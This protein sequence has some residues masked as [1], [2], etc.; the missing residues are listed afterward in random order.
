MKKHVVMIFGL[1]LAVSIFAQD[2]KSIKMEDYRLDPKI[3]T[4]LMDSLK[5]EGRSIYQQNNEFYVLGWSKDGKMA[6][7]EN[8]GIEGRGG[9]DLLFVILDLVED[10]EVFNKKISWYDDDGYGEIPGN[11]MS[12]TDCI[13]RNSAEFNREL[14]KNGIILKPSKVLSVPFV[15]DKNNFFDFDINEIKHDYGEYG[16]LEMTYEIIARK[17]KS[18]KVLNRVEDKICSYVLPTGYLKSPYENRIAL[19][20]ADVE[21]VFEGS[22]VFVNFYGCNLSKGFNKK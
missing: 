20:V 11:C 17:N 14:K 4:V 2:I 15:D 6:Y 5:D 10:E 21:F 12:F 9:H 3:T 19:I 13:N 7:I 16:L 22:E 1:M 8:R 18:Y